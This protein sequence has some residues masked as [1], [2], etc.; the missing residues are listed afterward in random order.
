MKSDGCPAGYDGTVWDPNSFAELVEGRRQL[1]PG[2]GVLFGLK[3]EPANST[4]NNHARM[5]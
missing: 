4:G 5:R 3:M 2:Q 1:P